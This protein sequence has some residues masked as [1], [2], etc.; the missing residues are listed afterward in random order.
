MI[1]GLITYRLLSESSYVQLPDELKST[2][3][4]VI[5]IKNN[6][7]KCFSWYHVR[8]VNAVKIHPERIRRTN[9]K[10]ANGLDYG[11]I[12]FPVWEKDFNKIETK[13][14]ICINLY[15]YESRLTF[16]IYLSDQK[17]ENSMDLLLVTDENK[18]HFVYI[19]DFD[20]FV[21]HKT[22]NKKQKILLQELFIVF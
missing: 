1:I 17:P 20:R 4:G 18:S 8:H 7:Q 10:L 6:K 5:N 14:N 19:K 3:K 22:K 9:K 12:E 2:K 21:F 15:R 16:P 13:N 11:G